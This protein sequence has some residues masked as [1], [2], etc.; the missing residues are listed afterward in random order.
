MNSI[1]TLVTF[2]WIL[3]QE[4]LWRTIYF[5]SFT[6]FTS[7]L[8]FLLSTFNFLEIR[9]RILQSERNMKITPNIYLQGMG[10]KRM[11]EQGERADV[12]EGPPS[13]YYKTVPF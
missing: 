2:V 4:S 13:S 10:L 3:A 12:K 7:L 11:C 6:F 8:Y 5:I 9:P 1:P